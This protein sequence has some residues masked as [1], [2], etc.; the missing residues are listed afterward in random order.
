MPTIASGKQ[1]L[2]ARTGQ[3]LTPHSSV[4]AS[5]KKQRK[6]RAVLTAAPSG[7]RPMN[8]LEKKANVKHKRLKSN[9]NSRDW[10]C[11]STGITIVHVIPIHAPTNM[12]ASGRAFVLGLPK[13]TDKK[14]VGAHASR[15]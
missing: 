8:A 10:M 15:P 13:M 6:L 12:S 1:P 5:Q 4:S 7:K 11:A 2:V 14:R 9:T 3:S